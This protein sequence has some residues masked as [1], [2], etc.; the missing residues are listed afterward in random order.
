VLEGGGS[1]P[2]DRAPFRSQHLRLWHRGPE[3][4]LALSGL[5]RRSARRWG[6][7]TLEG[8]S[9]KVQAHARTAGSGPEGA[10]R[11]PGPGGDSDQELFDELQ[12]A[13]PFLTAERG[14]AKGGTLVHQVQLR[15]AAHCN[16]RCAFCQS[17]PSDRHPLPSGDELRECVGR[18]AGLLPGAKWTLTGGEPTLREDL[19]ELT[20]HLLSHP[21]VER[22]SIQTNAVNIGRKPASFPFTRS[23]RLSFLI[24]FHHTREPIY[25][26]CTETRGQLQ[27]AVQ[28]IR[29]LIELGYVPE[30]NCVLT[31]HNV[32]HLDEMVR[33]LPVLFDGTVLPVLHFTVM[34]A[35]DHRQAADLFVP[36]PHLISR[37]EEALW[38]ADSMG[39]EARVSVSAHH[40]AV[41]PCLL[42]PRTRAR[43]EYPQVYEH[44]GGP[45]D[46][47]ERWVKAPACEGCAVEGVCLGLPRAYVDC[48]GLAELSPLAEQ[49]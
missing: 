22:V 47:A 8:I 46:D 45:G 43:S 44:A 48:F 15:V 17:P 14:P 28:G 10:R 39:A 27:H 29:H 4:P 1:D 20:D 30:L 2:D 18:V 19:V 49:P 38:L 6:G 16:Q 35:P 42:G 13:Y 11:P 7:L 31:V 41:P 32:D 37:V 12:M 5:L 9:E 36:Y 33:D 24:G 23:E 25:D 21:E 40:T 3:L 26:R 34:A